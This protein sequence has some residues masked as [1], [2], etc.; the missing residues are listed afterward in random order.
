MKN[1][2]KLTITVVISIFTAIPAYNFG[3]STS[4]NNAIG[5]GKYLGYIGAQDLEFRT[6]NA[7]RMKLNRNVSYDI[8]GFNEPRDGF[9]WIGPD[10][11]LGG[12]GSYYNNKGA[13]SLLHLNGTT[14]IAAFELGYRPW[15][16]T[17]ITFTENSDMMYIGRKNTNPEL[18]QTDAVISWSDDE[19]S[20]P[21][22]GPDNMLFLFTKGNASSI[23]NPD[24]DHTGSGMNG[25]EIMRLTA[26]GNVGI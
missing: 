8:N 13:F 4:D 25:R 14:A 20:P 24:G 26:V 21:W 12:G 15:M 10:A 6:N 3:Q 16:K 19:A 1:V 23:S 2:Q 7:N 18:D 5:L 22:S 11:P 17:G 9:L